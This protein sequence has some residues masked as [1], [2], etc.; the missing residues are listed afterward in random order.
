MEIERWNLYHHR[1]IVSYQNYAIASGKRRGKSSNQYWPFG[2]VY[3]SIVVY[4][5]V[6]DLSLFVH[7]RKRLS[8][9]DFDK[10]NQI[11]TSKALNKNVMDSESDSEKDNNTNKTYE[12]TLR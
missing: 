9:D 2:I 3:L 11:I 10:M 6:F 1:S 12:G 4:D 5:P 7:I 8:N